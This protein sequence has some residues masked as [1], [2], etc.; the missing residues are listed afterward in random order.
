MTLCT[1]RIYRIRLTKGCRQRNHKD[2]TINNISRLR[3]NETKANH[4][5][6]EFLLLPLIECPSF[7]ITTVTIIIPLKYVT[8]VHERTYFKAL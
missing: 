4:E 8:N 2:A 1:L 7:F 5:L 6:L 3:L